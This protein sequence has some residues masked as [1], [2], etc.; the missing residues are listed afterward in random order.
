MVQ[1]GD[2]GVFTAAGLPNITGT[3]VTTYFVFRGTNTGALLG[4]ATGQA[5]ASS[6]MFDTSA[7]NGLLTLDASSSNS[8]YG[9]STTVQPPAVGAK[10]YIQVF[11][12]AVPA[13]MAQAGE[14]I[15]MLEAKADKTELENYL[16][17]SG[18]TM[19]GSLL[20]T[21]E[22]SF[23]FENTTGKIGILF[24]SSW[25]NGA[26]IWL[27]GKDHA[28]AGCFDINAHNGTTSC[29]L[30]GKADGTLTWAGKAVQCVHSSG[31][32]Y[33]R[34]TSGLQICWGTL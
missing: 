21:N 33:I 4:A 8:I 10:L 22:N 9:N 28:Q 23:M 26:N 13:S 14:F 5:T 6:P 3:A 15:N 20:T 19:T 11:T 12:S 17:L 31:T 29:Q 34:Y 32:Y 16:P 7:G 18:G 27:H 30:K 2:V 24:N 25:T 1:P